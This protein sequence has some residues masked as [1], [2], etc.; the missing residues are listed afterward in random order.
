MLGFG[1]ADVH[2]AAAATWTYPGGP[3]THADGTEFPSLPLTIEAC[4]YLRATENRTVFYKPVVIT[5]HGNNG[6]CSTNASGQDAPGNF[7]W[8]APS[9]AC[10][11]VL[12]STFPAWINGQ[13]GNS[14]PGTCQPSQVVPKIGMDIALPIFH[15]ATGSG[16]NV[17]YRVRGMAVFH[18]TGFNLHGPAG[19]A[20]P[21]ANPPCSGNERCIAGWFVPQ[22]Q[23]AAP[24]GGDDF[25]MSIISLVE[26]AP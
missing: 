1:T 24:P 8:I 12:P 10:E 18:L 15:Q 3:V 16:S 21:P 17:K 25:G 13:T 22:S 2:A 4:E 26:E 11:A 14:P 5:F 20:S 7:G 23:V 9:S 6:F 19:W